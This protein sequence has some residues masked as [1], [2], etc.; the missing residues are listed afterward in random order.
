MAITIVISFYGIQIYSEPFRE[1]TLEL[2]FEEEIITVLIRDE[3][4]HGKII[5]I[6]L[7]ILHVSGKK[8]NEN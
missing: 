7:T 5:L 8:S 6:I 4:H 3:T 2:R 1:S